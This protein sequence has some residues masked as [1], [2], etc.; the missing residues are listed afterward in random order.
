MSGG[1]APTDFGILAL[2]RAAEE[3]L[4]LRKVGDARMHAEWLLAHILGKSRHE[5]YLRP[6][7]ETAPEAAETFA[8]LV[9]RRAVG[10]PTQYIVGETE[11]YGLK[12][13][14]DRRA[15]IPRPETEFLVE[16]AL[17]LA[18]AIER[19]AVTILDLGTGSGCIA[20]SLAVHLPTAR[21]VASDVEPAA[22]ELARINATRHGVED[23]IEFRHSDLFAEIPE[24]FDLVVANLPYVSTGEKPLLQREVRDWEPAAALF[25]G[26]DGLEY[27]EPVIRQA[28]DHVWL[29][30]HLLLEIGATQLAA[31]K[32]LL[33]VTGRFTEVRYVADYQGHPRVVVARRL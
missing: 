30:G 26:A 5:L 9:T 8:G 7:E 2:L 33:E 27:L 32:G 25:A 12:L 11:F 31:V 3:Y 22:L 21:L 6:Q 18:L 14:C 16:K 4:S 20:V 29:A 1:F 13:H 28:A 15:L 24:D 23:R 10:E 19:K 17:E